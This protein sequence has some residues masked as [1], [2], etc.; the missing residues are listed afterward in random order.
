MGF[1]DDFTSLKFASPAGLVLAPTLAFLLIAGYYISAGLYNITFH[2]LAKYPGPKSYAFTRLTWSI[3]VL[4]GKSCFRLAALHNKY[5]DT[6]RI[7]PNELSYTNSRVWK[8]V[9]GSQPG[10]KPQ[11]QKDPLHYQKHDKTPSLHVSSDADHTR[12]RRLIAHAFSDKALRD[13]EYIMQDYSSLLISRLREV[14]AGG[15]TVNIRQWYHWALFDLFGDL[16][17]CEPFGCLRDGKSHPWV[18]II[19]QSIQAFMYI[20]L[21]R[22]IPGLQKLM[23]KMMPK[24]K[25]E[26][27]A[28]HT[29]FSSDLADK[30]MAMQT[31]RPDFMSFLLKYN[32]EKGL[33]IPEIRSNSNVLIPGGSETTGTFLAGATWHLLKNPDKM[34]KLVNEVRGAFA[35]QEEITVVKLNQ[36][37]YLTAVIEEGLRVY[38]P[39]PSNMPRMIPPEGATVCGKWVPGGTSVAVAPWPMF[40]SAANFS[41]PTSFIPERWLGDPLYTHDDRA[42]FQPFSSGPRNCIGKNLAYAEMRMVMAKM[43]WNF[44]LVLQPESE[45]WFPHEMVVVWNIPPLHIKLIPVVREPTNRVTES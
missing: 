32:D 24:K 43:V 45:N 25:I 21:A 12:M 9:F 20:G 41:D 39:V 38:P 37:K 27:A 11:M 31:D 23:M 18:D 26:Q 17:Y 7:G 33:S 2:P 42:A 1:L 22:R 28:W 34:K 8:D 35:T 13:Q 36:L 15:T 5:G 3:D 29:K 16:C 40:T 14:S 10:G 19:G 44:D 6:V 30:R 4:S